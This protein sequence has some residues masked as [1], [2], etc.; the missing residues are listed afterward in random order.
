M[1][2]A[3]PAVA[4]GHG[5][6]AGRSSGT[7]ATASIAARHDDHHLAAAE[8]P[9]SW[10]EFAKRRLRLQFQ[11]ELSVESEAARRFYQAMTRLGPAS[12]AAPPT[13]VVRAWVM[14]DG[15][16]WRLELED[17]RDDAAL[18]N[19][20]VILTGG[21]IGA[22]PP[23]PQPLRLRLSLHPRKKPG[24]LKWNGEDRHDL[25]PLPWE[26]SV[27]SGRAGC[28]CCGLCGGGAGGAHRLIPRAS[29][30]AMQPWKTLVP[31]LAS[32]PRRQI[33]RA[34]LPKNRRA[35]ACRPQAP[36]R[37]PIIVH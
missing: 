14:A 17:Y 33:G 36:M 20:Y 1:V 3:W 22:A 7:K 37:S 25:V 34:L 11:Q 8:T 28:G 27:A 26:M 30:P 9:A 35:R 24:Q 12:D 5:R 13:L 4:P 32:R 6:S 18:D 10:Q 23:M 19:L 15:K 16:V 21:G 29:L 2:A 31:R